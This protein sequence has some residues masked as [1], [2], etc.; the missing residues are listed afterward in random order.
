MF[1]FRKYI[2]RIIIL[3]TAIL[4]FC[5]FL[6]EELIKKAKIHHKVIMPGLTHLQVAQPISFGHHL[7][8]YEAMFARDDERDKRN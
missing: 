1:N 7:L 8:A 4:L 5:F 3:L 2:L 6:R